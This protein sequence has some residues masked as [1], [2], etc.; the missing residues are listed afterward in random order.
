[1]DAPLVAAERDMGAAVP[2]LETR[3]N[4]RHA[5]H[6]GNFADLVKLRP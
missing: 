3:L 2:E 5:Y 1:M 4:Y 6:A